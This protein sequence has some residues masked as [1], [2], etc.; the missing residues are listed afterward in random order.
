[1][2]T[3]DEQRFN[4]KWDLIF[5]EIKDLR[6]KSDLLYW[7]DELYMLNDSERAVLI[8]A[9]IVKW[10]NLNWPFANYMYEIINYFFKLDNVYK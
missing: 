1:M 4:N 5:K 8:N 10:K 9:L 6:I 3:I 7:R 2:I